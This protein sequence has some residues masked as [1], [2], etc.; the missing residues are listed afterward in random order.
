MLTSKTIA[1]KVIYFHR[2]DCPHN[3]TS[4]IICYYDVFTRELL[5]TQYCYFLS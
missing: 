2:F 5:V 4:P 1:V 3:R